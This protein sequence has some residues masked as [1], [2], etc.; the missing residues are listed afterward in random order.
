MDRNRWT[1]CSDLNIQGTRIG[2]QN[3]WA[4]FSNLNI[5]GTRI[6]GHHIQTGIFMEVE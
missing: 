2:D 3:R 5:H 1:T 6:C 4:S